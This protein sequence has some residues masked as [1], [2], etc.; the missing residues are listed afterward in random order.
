MNYT[1]SI[2]SESISHKQ[3]KHPR[4]SSA[5]SSGQIAAQEKIRKHDF[6]KGKRAAPIIP[7][8]RF[9]TKDPSKSKPVHGRKPKVEPKTELVSPNH[10]VDDND[11]E[12]V[13]PVP[14]EVS[15]SVPK[16]AFNTTNQLKKFKPERYFKCPKCGI[17]KGTTQWL[18]EDYPE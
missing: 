16:G 11:T 14:D 8:W 5:P 3:P 17:H 1:D 18:N 10:N 2:D 7:P 15:D 12:P 6:P 4:V 13:T 9:V